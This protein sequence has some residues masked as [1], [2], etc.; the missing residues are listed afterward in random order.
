VPGAGGEACSERRGEARSV[1][2]GVRKGKREAALRKLTFAPGTKK[3][4]REERSAQL[5]GENEN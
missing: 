1:Q 3:S 5:L 4:R 2:G